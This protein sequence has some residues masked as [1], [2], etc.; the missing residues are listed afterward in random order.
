M[1]VYAARI[2]DSPI[3]SEIIFCKSCSISDI[4]FKANLQVDLLVDL[5]ATHYQ[6][7]TILGENQFF[8]GSNF[9]TLTSAKPHLHIQTQH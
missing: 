9:Y 8:L 2:H 6:S 5:Y 4:I 3:V 1:N 7:P